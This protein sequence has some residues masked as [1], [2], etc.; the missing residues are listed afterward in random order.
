MAPSIKHL[1]FRRSI[2][3]ASNSPSLAI[4]V[5]E[6]NQAL[7]VTVPTDADTD[8]NV[9]AYSHPTLVVHSNTTPATDYVS[10]WHDATDGYINVASGNLKFAIDGTAELTLTTAALA[11]TTSDGNA[12]GTMSLMWADLFLASAGVINFNN[13]DVTLTHGSHI[14]TIGAADVY[15]ADTYGLIVGYT[16]QETVSTGDGAT[17][18]VPEVQVWGTAMADASVLIGLSSA[19]DALGP[20]LAFVKSGNATIGTHTAVA[21]DEYVGR[22]V[23]FGDDGTD[24]ETPV[25]EIRF[26]V[27][28]AGGPGASAIGGSLEFYTTADGG[29]TLTLAMTISTA[30]LVTVASGLSLTTGNV[31]VGAVGAFATTEPASAVICKSGTEPAGAVV[32][33][34]G[35]H[36][37]ATVLRKI[38]AD[39]TV[40]N[41]G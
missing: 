23:A 36:A 3:D 19:T 30:Q 18:L 20:T 12:L 28:D 41:V 38:I 35:I 6:T 15:V 7:H 1:G 22:I 5:E 34:S 39:G 17:D 10:L 4:C 26:V 29:T 14:L 31:K 25:A 33:A 2:G 21:N 11:P 24:L 27:D 16:A 13:G 32:T 37:N 8:W 9:S 40:S